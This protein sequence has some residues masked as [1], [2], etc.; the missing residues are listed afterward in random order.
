MPKSVGVSTD[1]KT[2]VTSN[3]K[4][5]KTWRPQKKSGSPQS[6]SVSLKQKLINAFAQEWKKYY[7]T[8]Y[9]PSETDS[10]NVHFNVVPTVE[11]DGDFLSTW[12]ETV[13]EALKTNIIWT[14]GDTDEAGR[15]TLSGFINRFNDIKMLSSDDEGARFFYTAY[16]KYRQIWGT[17]SLAAYRS[18]AKV[19][20][21]KGYR[22]AQI[23]AGLLARLKRHY[24]NRELG[25]D[26]CP[27]EDRRRDSVT[28]VEAEL[29]GNPD[30]VEYL[31]RRS[32]GSALP[33]RRRLIA[34][35]MERQGDL[36]AHLG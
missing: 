29:D 28:E 20:H 15:P 3:K 34:A 10:K 18:A 22:L 26:Q 1:R 17:D 21:H 11:D 2:K 25:L 27:E 32:R 13:R 8:R 36:C 35:Y 23:D 16:S 5:T 4:K 6:S 19:I 12:R 31:F 24:S 14:D 33:I 30:L 7:G 9:I